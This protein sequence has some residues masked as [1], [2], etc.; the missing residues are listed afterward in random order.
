[1]RCPWAVRRQVLLPSMRS[2][3]PLSGAGRG[4]S[5]SGCG[6]AL[7]EQ[8]THLG[9]EAPVGEPD[10]VIQGDTQGA[11]QG[12]DPRVAESLGWSPP[13]VGGDRRSATRSKA[14]F[15]RT[16]PWPT[17]SVPISRALASRSIG[18][19][20]GGNGLVRADQ[21]PARSRGSAD[22]RRFRP[23]R[24]PTIRTK[25]SLDPGIDLLAAAS[26]A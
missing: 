2:I 23:R 24:R 15:A 6:C 18:V 19:V 16:Q 14:G 7:A 21:N 26:T 3:T 10:D 5:S 25:E 4:R 13:A 12:H 1:M 20:L 9:A 8:M 22:G 17:R 11:D